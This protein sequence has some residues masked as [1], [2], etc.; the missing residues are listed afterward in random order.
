M[1]EVRFY[2]TH[3]GRSQ[4]T[5]FLDE[6]LGRDRAQVVADIMAFRDHGL[7]APISM[8]PIRGQQNRGMFEIR[9]GGFRT[10]FCQKSGVVWVL[11]VCK[12]QDQDAGI[13]AAR[14]RMKKL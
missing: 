2:T 7:Q 10:F 11:H 6:L 4:P 1:F 9:T 5:E 13:A 3:A 14:G 8:K 12:K